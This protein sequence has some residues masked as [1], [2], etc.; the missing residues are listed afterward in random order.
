MRRGEKSAAEEPFRGRPRPGKAEGSEPKTAPEW[1]RLLPAVPS[2][3]GRSIPGPENAVSYLTLR[4][5]PDILPSSPV[6]TPLVYR[7]GAQR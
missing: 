6:H 2:P 3:R 5:I 1:M 7:K 4:E